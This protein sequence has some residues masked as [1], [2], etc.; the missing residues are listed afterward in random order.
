MNFKS[1]AVIFLEKGIT[2]GRECSLV[3]RSVKWADDRFHIVNSFKGPNG[4]IYA[5]GWK[6]KNDMFSS[7]YFDSVNDSREWELVKV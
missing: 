3:V 2:I 4:E 6:M 1:L 5:I 7:P